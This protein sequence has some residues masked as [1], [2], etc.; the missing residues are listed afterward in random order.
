MGELATVIGVEG[1]HDLV[2]VASVDGHN[3]RVLRQRAEKK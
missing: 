1:L 3:R 2:E